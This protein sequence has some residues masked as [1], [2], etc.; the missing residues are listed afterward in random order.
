M[1][2]LSRNSHLT[3]L[4]AIALGIALGFTSGAA[5]FVLLAP[6]IALIGVM[7]SATIRDYRNQRSAGRQ[8]RELQQLLDELGQ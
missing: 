1:R 2:M 5:T 4:G 8:Q 7:A 6:L 3:F